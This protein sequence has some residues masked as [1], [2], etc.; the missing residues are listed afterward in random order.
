M[1][2]IAAIFDYLT[3]FNGFS[4]IYQSYK[5]CHKLSLFTGNHHDVP[6]VLKGSLK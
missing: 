5:I 1:T 3:N 6:W 2:L 4:C